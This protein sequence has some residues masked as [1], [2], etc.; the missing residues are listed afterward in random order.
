MRF[1]I[2][3]SDNISLVYKLAEHEISEHW[4]S[5]IQQ[6]KID[7]CCKINYYTGYNDPILVNQRINRLFELADIINQHVPKKIEKVPF[8]KE[9]FGNVLNIMHVH[10][11]E[12]KSKA[13]YEMLNEYLTEYND[14]IHWL[15]SILPDYYNKVFS[16]SKFTIKLDFNKVESYNTYTIP[17][18]AYPMFNEYF[19]FGQLML[20]YVHVGKHAWELFFANDLVCPKDQYVP[21]TEYN[22][23]VRLH[24]YNNIM[25]QAPV[26]NMF[27]KSWNNFYNLKGGKDFF[28]HEF[29]DP[30]IGFGYCQIGHLEQIF[31]DN[32]LITT[33]NNIKDIV[34][35]VAKLVKTSIVD[36]EIL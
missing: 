29:D 8:T 13:G 3:F 17:E 33:P 14:I 27:K 11:P 30:K 2:N 26:R 4:A 22:A 6:R 21:Q 7:E 35:F 23:S 5:L 16:N 34:E 24:F 25:D 15:E 12:F 28:G 18:S 10:F 1:K 31:I 36:W 9:N 32:N 20:H 19:S